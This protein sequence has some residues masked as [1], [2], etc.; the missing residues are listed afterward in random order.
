MSSLKTAI[1]P[2]NPEVQ[3]IAEKHN[4]HAEAILEIFQEIQDRHGGL[5][6]EL[7]TDV[8]H[9][10]KIPPHKAYGVATFYSMLSLNPQ[11]ETTIHIC[12]GPVCWLKGAPQ[13]QQMFEESLA[14]SRQ[15]K[16][17]R[18]S[19]LGLCDR[20]PA[21][22]IENVQTGPL[23]E[24]S[25]ANII[26]GWR[27]NPFDYSKPK[28][29]EMR[30]MLSK[31]GIIDPDSIQS[32]LA[33]GG[34]D[35]FKTAIHLSPQ[36]VI[37]TIENSGLMGR[38]GAG[39]PVGRK[40]RFVAHAPGNPKYVIC[41]ADESEPLVF[42]DRVLI[43][44]N[45]HQL[46][47]GILIAGYAT[48]ATEAYIYIRGEY[49]S[50]ALRLERAIEQAKNEA[51]LGNNIL[52]S[53]F[54]FNINVHRGAGAYICGEETALI[55]SLEGKRGEP[56]LRP[57]YPPA[58]GFRGQP[59]LVNNVESL[60]ALPAILENGSEWYRSLHPGD[61]PGTKLFMIL[62]HINHPA[63]FEAPYG[64]S[65]KQMIDQFGGGLLDGSRFHFA[66]TG[67]AAGTFVPEELLDIPIDYSSAA[68]GLSLGAGSFLICDDSISPVDLLGQILHFFVIESCGKCTP[69]RQGTARAL[70][71]LDRLVARNGE[72]SD[73]SEL[74]KL[75]DVLQYD[76]FCGLG[77]SAAIPI[78]SAL[79]YFREDFLACIH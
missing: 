22:L 28:A 39:F 9:A 76:S 8:A 79:H 42:K 53:S 18:T 59:T 78:K 6:A 68:K 56:R 25:L 55:E 50:Q 26:Q 47:E 27:G 74:L 67:G 57:P 23:T 66:L 30:V 71:I 44:T 10:I 17:Q 77:Q 72:K 3:M 33:N 13:I 65:L 4:F 62:G 43:D 19:C 29:G 16:V 60:S 51:L 36:E 5:T 40:M 2:I 14:E 54:S 15:W 73:I 58:Y 49:Y 69:C 35:G 41:N 45:P 64:L 7:I 38:G 21:A 37:E 63:I 46:L 52:N 20:A 70:T 11:K 1:K 61:T 34:Y 32:A 12:D 24:K 75:A 31:T 48:G